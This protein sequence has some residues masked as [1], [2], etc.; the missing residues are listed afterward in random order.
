[1][2][3]WIFEPGHTEVES[4]ARRDAHVGPRSL[5][6]GVVVS[7][8]VDLVLDVEAILLKDLERTV[9]IDYYRSQAEAT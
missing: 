1:M 5:H 3:T 7:D 8:E 6:G 4:R 9:A 2:A